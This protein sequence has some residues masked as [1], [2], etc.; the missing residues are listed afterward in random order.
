MVLGFLAFKKYLGR[1]EMRT[2]E[3]STSGEYGQFEISPE[4]IEP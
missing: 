2:R 1:I 3:K 4:A